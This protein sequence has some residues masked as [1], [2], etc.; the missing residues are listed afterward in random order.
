LPPTTLKKTPSLSVDVLTKPR[1]RIGL[2]FN[3]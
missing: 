2:F 1:D 3:S